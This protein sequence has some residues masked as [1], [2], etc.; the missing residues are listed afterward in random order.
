MPVKRVYEKLK[1]L[2]T[3]I[4]RRHMKKHLFIIFMMVTLLGVGVG[5]KKNVYVGGHT[6]ISSYIAMPGY[7]KN[8]GS[9]IFLVSIWTEMPLLLP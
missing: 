5:Y 3:T 6:K 1:Q 2:H 4:G 9:Q 7:W 8:G